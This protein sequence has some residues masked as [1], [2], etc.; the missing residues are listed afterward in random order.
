[1]MRSGDDEK[2][3]QQVCRHVCLGTRRTARAA[4]G[5]DIYHIPPSAKRNASGGP[6]KVC[7]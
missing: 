1:M 4:H 7:S 2:D 3:P 5:T 6:A